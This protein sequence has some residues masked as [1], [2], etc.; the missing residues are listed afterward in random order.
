MKQLFFLI[1]ILLS[2]I[3]SFASQAKADGAYTE[4]LVD[5]YNGRILKPVPSVPMHIAE[6]HVMEQAGYGLVN[7]RTRYEKSL[8]R[9]KW[10]DWATQ[11]MRGNRRSIRIPHGGKVVGIAAREQ[12]GYGIINARLRYKLGNQLRWTSWVTNNQRGHVVQQMCQP[13]S[14]GK[15]I[16]VQEQS[17]YG[18]INLQL[19][20]EWPN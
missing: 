5:N 7:L 3:I 16:R 11:N 1:S 15:A 13:G 20:C 10:S 8:G 12:S 17:G 9:L 14:Y 19:Y 6:L 4:W 18:I 2:I